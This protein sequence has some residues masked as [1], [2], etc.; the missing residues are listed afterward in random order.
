MVQ[1]TFLDSGQGAPRG[2][3]ILYYLRQE[4]DQ[5]AEIRLDILDAAG[6]TI[7]V[8]RPKPHDY[9]SWDDNRKSVN[10]G[11]WIPANRGVNRFAWNL[12]LP[13]PVRVP[14]NKTTPTANTGPFVLPGMYSI[15]LT[16]GDAF[17]TVSLI[18]VNDP[19]SQ[20]TQPELEEQFVL[21]QAIYAKISSAHEGINRLRSVR[22]Q[23]THWKERLADHS[24][25]L[26]AIDGLLATLAAVEDELILPGEHKD[27]FGLNERVRLNAC[28]TSL[29]SVVASADG[30]PTRQAAELA[31]EYGAQVDAALARLV[32]A[33]DRD[34]ALVNREI[35]E[36]AVQPIEAV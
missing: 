21:L 28:L 18:I 22:S 4:P 35:Q 24:K 15:R 1:R 13:E 23:L 12:R 30:R 27:T 26:A 9:D 29:I 31:A 3:G 14:G 8:Y 34:L 5:E 19:R 25:A 11:P 33:L 6:R 2:A 16:V 20:A 36:S 7:A 10:T 17:E 32:A